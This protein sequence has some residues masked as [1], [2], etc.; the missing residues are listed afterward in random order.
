M[1]VG[2]CGAGQLFAG[3]G[4]ERAEGLGNFGDEGF[5]LQVAGGGEEHVRRGEAAGVLG[6]HDGLGEGGDGFGGAE[7]RAAEGVA[8]P[9]L[10]GEELMDQVVGVVLIHL[11][12]FQDDALFFLNV[13]GGEG[14]VQDEVGEQVKG[15]GNVRVEDLDGEADGFLGGVGVQVAADGVDLAG[16]LLR[17]AGGGALEDH[18]LE[19]VGDAVGLGGFVAGAGVEPDAHGDRAQGGHA[20]GEDAEAVGQGGG[21]DV[22]GG[23]S[24]GSVFGLRDGDGHHRLLWHFSPAGWK[25]HILAGLR[26]A[27]QCGDRLC[28]EHGG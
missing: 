24:A 18:V 12:L 23:R 26:S 11:D 2:A 25:R 17:R 9:E 1:T 7:D 22:A 20:F 10:L 8:G 21:A 4:G 19:E 28:V 16:K 14:G 27:S 5:V 13:V 6:E 3:A 15:D